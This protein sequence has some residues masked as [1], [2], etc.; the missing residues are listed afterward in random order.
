MRGASRI[1]GVDIN[2]EKFSKGAYFSHVYIS[3]V[4]FFTF[5]FPLVGQFLRLCH[6]PQKKNCRSICAS[7]NLIN[8]LVSLEYDVTELISGP[9]FPISDQLIEI[10]KFA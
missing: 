3:A 2:P 8:T 4:P 6:A 5:F 1:I 7:V 10:E 9:I